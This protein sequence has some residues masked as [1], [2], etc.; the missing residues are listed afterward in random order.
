MTQQFLHV[1]AREKIPK[2]A[3]FPL[4]PFPRLDRIDFQYGAPTPA[5]WIVSYTDTAAIFSVDGY[6]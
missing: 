4:A 1:L 5:P 2:H 3:L 6:T